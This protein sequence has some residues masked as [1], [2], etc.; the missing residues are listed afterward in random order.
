[1]WQTREKAYQCKADVYGISWRQRR[2]NGKHRVAEGRG[3]GRALDSEVLICSIQV[4]MW[5]EWQEK[6]EE[7]NMEGKS[8]E[9]SEQETEEEEEGGGR[10]KVSIKHRRA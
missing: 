1:M 10:Q 6:E 2:R 7:L 5:C 4:E 3:V 9:V 8:V